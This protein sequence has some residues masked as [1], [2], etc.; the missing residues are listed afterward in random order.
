[1]SELLNE[2]LS[3]LLDGEL[4]PEET[5]LLLRRLGRETE[6]A[7]T[8]RPASGPSQRGAADRLGAAR[9]TA[10]AGSAAITALTRSVKSAR[11]WTRSPRSTS[12]HSR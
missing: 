12:P 6:L 1:M 4:P 3:A 10:N 7:A 5:S 8:A 2:Q 9:G 11:G